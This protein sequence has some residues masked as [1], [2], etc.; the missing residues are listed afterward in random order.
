[1]VARCCRHVFMCVCVCL[2]RN[3]NGSRSPFLSLPHLPGPSQLFPCLPNLSPCPALPSLLCQPTHRLRC[4]ACC[5]ALQL[6]NGLRHLSTAAAPP[7][8]AAAMKAGETARQWLNRS[9][10]CV[11]LWCWGLFVCVCVC[12]RQGLVLSETGPRPQLLLA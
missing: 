9:A 7:K 8:S 12:V 3:S 4:T 2:S 1:M 10:V 11:V 6:L 5:T